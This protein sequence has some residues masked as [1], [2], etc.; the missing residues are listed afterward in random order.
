MPTVA[1][2]KGATVE[3]ILKVPPAGCTRSKGLRAPAGTSGSELD[4]S[5]DRV[6][7]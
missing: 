1:G 6:L 3:A 7:K 2:P 4:D 5:F